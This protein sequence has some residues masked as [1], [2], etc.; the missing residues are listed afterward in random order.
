MPTGGTSIAG[1]LKPSWYSGPANPEGT[2][3]AAAESNVSKAGSSAFSAA[4]GVQR[5]K[6]LTICFHDLMT[7]TP[8]WFDS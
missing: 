1:S 3:F 2:L 7:C 8:L 4:C 5:T 6:P